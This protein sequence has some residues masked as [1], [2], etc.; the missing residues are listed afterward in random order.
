LSQY[1]HFKILEAEFK[2]DASGQC[3]LSVIFL[4][5]YINLSKKEL[6]PVK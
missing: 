5:R 1:T 6:C 4:F 2:E 3:H